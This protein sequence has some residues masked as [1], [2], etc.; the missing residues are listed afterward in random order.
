MLLG[1]LGFAVMVSLLYFSQPLILG[2]ASS[3]ERRLVRSLYSAAFLALFVM[4]LLVV[5]NNLF[6]I[7][8]ALL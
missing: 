6:Q 1:L 2:M 5:L 3:S 4:M 7:V 8:N